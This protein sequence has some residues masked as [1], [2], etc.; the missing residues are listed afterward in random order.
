MPPL[1]T[2]RPTDFDLAVG[3]Q[4]MLPATT[5]DG[6]ITQSTTD[7]HHTERSGAPYKTVPISP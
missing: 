2:R 7:G 1:S 3:A 6:P 5:A 4:Q